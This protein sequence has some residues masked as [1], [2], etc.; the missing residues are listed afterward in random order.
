MQLPAAFL[1]LSLADKQSTDVQKKNQALKMSEEAAPQ[2]DDSEFDVRKIDVTAKTT[3]DGGDAQTDWDYSTD[4]HPDDE[5]F[6][7]GKVERS[8]GIIIRGKTTLP[9]KK[10]E[11]SLETYDFTED[12]LQDLIDDAVGRPVFSNHRTKKGTKPAA[13]V[14]EAKPDEEGRVEV[15]IEIEDSVDGWRMVNAALNEQFI[16]FSWG[17]KFFLV[18]DKVSQKAVVD[19]R[20]CE[21]SITGNPEH[22]HDALITSVSARSAMHEDARKKLR[23]LLRSPEGH[24][25]FGKVQCV[26]K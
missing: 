10:G 24:A 12:D 5:R 3:D 14:V 26:G 13:R 8:S 16:G 25:L 9:M 6:K 17:T 4:L 23:A 2:I 19:K 20:L 15:A 1:T 7:K 11:H 22:K 21:L 18:D